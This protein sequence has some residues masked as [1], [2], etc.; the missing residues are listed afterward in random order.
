MVNQSNSSSD[1][2]NQPN[3][4]SETLSIFFITL[5]SIITIYLSLLSLSI[6]LKFCY[7]H[8]VGKE[9]EGAVSWLGKVGIFFFSFM[10]IGP[11]LG[12]I[13][14]M[15]GSGKSNYGGSHSTLY[16]FFIIIR[17]WWKGHT[18]PKGLPAFPGLPP[19]LGGIKDWEKESI[20]PNQNPPKLDPLKVINVNWTSESGI[21]GFFM[22]PFNSLIVSHFKSELGMKNIGDKCLVDNSE[23][24]CSG[25]IKGEVDES[26]FL[27]D[28]Y[29]GK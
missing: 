22:G 4:F 7:F 19:I 13:G 28:K 6:F 17:G 3:F 16:L 20:Y 1:S 9:Y 8:N 15:L 26:I 11:A 23:P 24:S 25:Y 29:V 14:G 21:K 12:A 18:I 27:G 5:T 10:L 2:Q